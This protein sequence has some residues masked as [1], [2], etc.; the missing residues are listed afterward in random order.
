M[1]EH[2]E[3]LLGWLGCSVYPSEKLNLQLFWS[4]IRSFNK[5]FRKAVYFLVI[6]EDIYGS[7]S[8]LQFH[9][10]INTNSENLRFSMLLFKRSIFQSLN[11]AHSISSLF[12]NSPF[13][14]LEMILSSAMYILLSTDVHIVFNSILGL[15]IR[16][17][18]NLTYAT[19]F[20]CIFASLVRSINLL[21]LKRDA[22]FFFSSRQDY[23]LLFNY[24]F[25]MFMVCLFG[26]MPFQP[27]WVI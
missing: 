8:N 12:F 4:Y 14:L 19:L 24:S 5:P 6:P 25:T 21:S 2:Q 18:H 9:K 23:S 26:F 17:F 7:G 16:L 11:I 10:S 22:T 1:C 27:L 13:K 15:F 20:T 3:V